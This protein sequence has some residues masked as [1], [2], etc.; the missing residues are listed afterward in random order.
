MASKAVV[1]VEDL[2][3]PVCCDIF[4][5][6]V[7]LSCSHSVCKVCLQQFWSKKGSQE[8][9]VCRR[10]A[11]KNLPP[12]NLALKNLCET[13]LQ[14]GS[15]RSSSGSEEFCS[16]HNER[17][18]L[19]CLHDRQPLCL[20]CRDSE[21][22]TN[23]KFRPLDEAVP[24]YR[25]ELK[26]ALKPL[27]EKLKF[28]KKVKQTCHESAEYIKTQA[29]HTEIRIREEFEKLHQFLRYEETARITALREEEEQK[30][31][32]M[33]EKMEEMSRE[34]SSLSDAIRAI[35]EEIKAEDIWLLKNF[36][37]TKR[38]AQC[39][40]QDPEM[41][42]GALINVAQHLGN[43]K[44]RVWEKMQD[45]VQYAPVILD[46]NTVGPYL[47]LSEDLTSVRFSDEKQQIPDNPER[48]DEFPCV[49][50]SE[51]INSGIHCWDVDAREN[52]RWSLGVITESNQRKGKTFFKTG[53]WRVQLHGGKY[54]LKASGE[55]STPL[56]V[57]NKLQRIRVELDWDRGKLSF[58]D[59]LN[60]T[61]LHTFTETFTERMFPY[62]GNG[63]KLSPLRILPVKSCVT[64]KQNIDTDIRE[65]QVLLSEKMASRASLSEEDFS[66]PV[67]CDVFRDPVVLSCSHSVCKDCLQQFWSKKGSQECPVCRRR[68]SK[69]MPPPN[70]ALKNLCEAFLQTRTQE[71]S[72]GSEEL[73]SLHSETL[74]FFCLEDKQPVC[75][76]C[77]TSGIHKNHKFCSINEAACKQREELRTALKPLQD[78]LKIFKDKKQN[79]NKTT[80]HIKNQ[81]VHTE[82]QIK[83]EFKKL[84]QFL[85]DEETASITALREEEEQ[86]SQMMK[87]K[88]EEINNEIS[89]LS[90][91]VRA[92]ENVLRTDDMSLLQDF[93][94]T[95]K[96]A[97]CTLDRLQNPEM[98]S[99]ALINVAKHLGNLK[100]RVW[101]KMQD[102]VQ[103]T[104]VI[105]DPNTAN[106]KLILSE[107][108]T[109]VKNS[110]EEQQIPDNPERFNNYLCV[111]G[112][113]GFNSGI[114]CWDVDVGDSTLWDLGVITESNQKKGDTFFNTGVWRIR[115]YDGKYWSWASERS[116]V[117]MTVN[118]K[119]QRIRVELDWDR[120]RLSFSDP[121]NNTNLHTFTHTFTERMFPFFY[122]YCKLSPLRV[123]PVKHCVTVEQHS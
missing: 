26:N 87:E 10:R 62:L 73:C 50:G 58:S 122:N 18:K 116:Y 65:G 101:E 57:N 3:C 112:S 66:C 79:W 40:L 11:S 94:T 123:L 111:L 118:N 107:D 56:T 59:P 91:T 110:D 75:E 106:P 38:R 36:D 51:G 109:S 95:I 46:P 8:C 78:K 29:K 31:Q 82:R 69:E 19:F 93:K 70:L 32:M 22:H 1:S 67:C 85:R 44:F 6:P 113:E 24:G 2:T 83:E 4:S 53:V 100:F 119:L 28:F 12:Y 71:T 117:P 43:L 37:F 120:G 55:S 13:Y 86:K 33:K 105:L 80:E 103:Y 61:H 96:R 108:L 39:T 68:S 60:N 15:Q 72:S 121:L 41:L 102:I 76:E 27:Q 97:E 74:K 52:T 25:E 30:S 47:I 48:F 63:C 49:L 14:E 84:H 64:V 35:I 9:P 7:F 77:Q 98:L 34:I 54:W 42:S 20:V 104:P 23:H 88:I 45:I 17:L 89:S 90:Q 114:H 5:D 21:K 92:I 99:G 115:L 16:L 81:T